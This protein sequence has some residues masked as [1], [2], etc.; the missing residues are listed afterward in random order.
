MGTWFR[1]YLYFPLGGSRVKTK[2]RLIFNFFVVWSLTG[3]WHGASWNYITWGL[4][5]FVLL[6][7]EKLTGI[8]GRFKNKWAKAGYRV[9]TL[10]AFLLGLVFVRANNMTEAF[11]YIATLFG[12][13]SNVLHTAYTTYILKNNLVL[14][15]FAVLLSTPVFKILR[16]KCAEKP[17]L[18]KMA[19]IVVPIVYLAMF[20]VSTSWLVIGTHHPFIYFNF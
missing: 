5:Y 12:F 16:E 7:F 8:P 17:M 3:L 10:L 14:L 9:F 18:E 15:I 6:T 19:K 2:S 11:R 20:F 1:D 4:M 13:T